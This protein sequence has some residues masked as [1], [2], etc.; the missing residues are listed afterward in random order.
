M[1]TNR[2]NVI[3]TT[4]VQ[5]A[6]VNDLTVEVRGDIHRKHYPCAV[7]SPSSAERDSSRCS[8]GILSRDTFL[9]TSGSRKGLSAANSQFAKQMPA[10]MWARLVV[11][12]SLAG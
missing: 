7:K 2:Q 8:A 1:L 11:W 4:R 6:A 10:G 9:P 3:S 5:A 12:Q